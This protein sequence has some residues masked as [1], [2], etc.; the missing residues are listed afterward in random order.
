[1]NQDKKAGMETKNPSV[2]IRG[3]EYLIVLA[4]VGAL[5]G[6]SVAPGVLWQDN[7]MAQVRVVE[8]DFVGDLGLALAHPLFYLIAQAFQSLPFSDSAYKTNLVSA[9]FG[10]LTVANFYLL[11]SLLL[12]KFV[13]RRHA[14]V[15]AALSLRL[16]HTFWQFSAMGEVYSVSTFILT[17]ELLVF[18]RF[19][20][21]GHRGWWLLLWFLN[22]LECSNHVL[23]LVT[24]SIIIL[25]SCFLIYRG[26][27]RWMWIFPA[28]ALWIVGCLPYEILGFQAWSKGES[29]KA[30]LHSMLFGQYQS[31]VLNVHI[32]IRL[33]GMA[34]AGIV[35]NFLTPN[36]LLIPAGWATAR[37]FISRGTFFF[38]LLLTVVHLAFAS[39]Y[40]V[41]DQYSF[42]IIPVLLLAIWLGFGAAWILTRWS[43]R[44]MIP[45]VLLA[46][47]PPVGYAFIPSLVHRVAPN[48]AAPPVAYRDAAEYFFWPWK[49]GYH[50]PDRLAEEVFAMA[51]PDAIV[52]ADSTTSRPFIYHQKA[53]NERT[54]ILVVSDLYGKIPAEEK[55]QKLTEELKLRQIYIVRPYPEYTPK[56]ILE[57]FRWVPAGPV[58]RIERV[59]EKGK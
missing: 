31:Q 30:V 42:F 28:A 22:G 40:P 20:N 48:F 24:L 56:W 35:L 58:Y 54:D 5:Y 47:I 52:I 33:L 19:T 37:K 39:R 16:A 51:K 34:M 7:G 12:A 53:K 13:I 11:V 2:R 6:I 45:L 9:V 36:V 46:L 3:W 44:A 4:L 25:W 38:L 15:L 17:C 8:R 49:T 43:K 41:R 59:L 57:H 50:G 26:Q 14:A 32:N 10:T 55:V 29:L 1:L 18:V 23:A 27:I 21:T